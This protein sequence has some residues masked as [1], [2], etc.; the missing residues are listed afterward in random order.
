MFWQEE[1][2]ELDVDGQAL[3]ASLEKMRRQIGPRSRLYPARTAHRRPPW[4]PTCCTARADEAAYKE[5][6]LRR[7]ACCSSSCCTQPTG[8]NYGTGL[9]LLA[10]V[11]ALLSSALC[12][13]LLTTARADPWGDADSAVCYFCALLLILTFSYLYFIWDAVGTENRASLVCAFATSLL[14]IALVALHC[15]VDVE[16]F[17][18]VCP[19]SNRL[20]NGGGQILPG[21]GFSWSRLPRPPAESDRTLW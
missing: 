11:D 3:P 1:P 5:Q 13:F 10:A 4:L 16:A 9:V 17:G 19:R 2:P 6:V 20:R 12:L 15:F 21:L 18:S 14:T 7:R 8:G